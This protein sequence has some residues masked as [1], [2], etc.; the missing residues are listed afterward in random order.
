MGVLLY[1]APM[2]GVTGAA[3]RRAHAAVFGGVTKYYAPFFSP[4]REHVM[5]PRV[6][7]ELLP[8]NN[9]GFTLVPQLL[10]RDADDFIWAA[11]TIFDM[12]YTEVNF[13]LGCP[14]GTVA[15][16]GK[17]SGFLACPDELDSFFERVFSALPGRHIS[18]KTRLGVE[19]ED[20]FPR[21]LGIYSRYPI[22]ELTVHARVRRDMYKLPVR[23]DSYALAHE[24]ISVPLC[25]NGD[26]FTCERAEEIC[27]RFPKTGALMLG[28]GL[29]ADPA[30]ARELSGGGRASREE[31]RRFHDLVYSGCARDFGNAN[32]TVPRMKELWSYLRFSFADC[33]K[34]YKRLAKSR[35][36][37]EYLDAAQDILSNIE[38][39]PGGCYKEG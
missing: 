35:R 27:R 7:R 29:I 32:V 1:C 39:A 23:P 30:L 37:E 15:A 18:V 31:L 8:A 22:Y 28:R 25:Y 34:E 5:P 12:G 24:R 14:S 10:C 9:P 38:L 26:V 6:K 13:N 16:K 11:Q 4:T 33:P 36:P 20:E 19:S 21:L 3:F 2:E 17:G